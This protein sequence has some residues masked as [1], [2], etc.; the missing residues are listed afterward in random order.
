[1][2]YKFFLKSEISCL[3]FSKTFRSI[4]IEI[5][6]KMKIEMLKNTCVLDKVAYSP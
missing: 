4:L 5:D 6:L 1:M 2:S 3:M